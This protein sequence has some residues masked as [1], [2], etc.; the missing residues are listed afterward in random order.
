[1]LELYGAPLEEIPIKKP[2]DRVKS[3][4]IDSVTEI[5]A[6]DRYYEEELKN[7]DNELYSL[8]QLTEEE[9]KFVED[10]YG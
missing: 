5:L 9:I 10:Y 2:N 3:S 8:F 1:M 4:I 6:N 7:I